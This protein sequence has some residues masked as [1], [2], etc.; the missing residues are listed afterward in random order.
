MLAA[1]LHSTRNATVAPEPVAVAVGVIL[2]CS[3]SSTEAPIVAAV[4]VIVILVAGFCFALFHGNT[5]EWC[6]K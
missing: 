3:S 1:Q 6:E 2:A 4:V 5:S